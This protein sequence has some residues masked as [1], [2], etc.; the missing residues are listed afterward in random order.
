MNYK[1]IEKK[2]Y[3]Y[4]FISAKENTRTTQKLMRLFTYK[5]KGKWRK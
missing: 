4:L 1:Y 5:D 2:L 3:M